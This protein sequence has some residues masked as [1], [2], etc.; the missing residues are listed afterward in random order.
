MP[1][2]AVAIPMPFAGI[3]TA[4]ANAL[5]TKN[6]PYENIPI[7]TEIV[8]A[9]TVPLNQKYDNTG[10]PNGISETFTGVP[11]EATPEP[12]F[13]PA[14][15]EENLQA[16]F[17]ANDWTDYLPI[18]L[19]TEARVQAMLA[20]TSHAADEVIKTVTW[21]GG[22]RQLTVEK[23]AICAVMAGASPKHFPAIL[24]ISTQ[25]P[26]GNSTTSMSN[27]IIFSGPIRDEIG[28]NYAG[29][30]MSPYS[31]A[32]AVC[33]RSLTIMSKTVGGL[34]AYG[35]SS[36][37]N[38]T[39]TTFSSLGSNIQY[40]NNCFGENEEALPPGWKT[41]AEIEGF[42]KL[43]SVVTV[44]TGWTYISS[45]GE[46]QIQTPVHEWIADYMHALSGQGGAT[47]FM[48]PLVANILY[49]GFNFDKE[50][51]AQYF[52]E[53]VVKTAKQLW[54]NGVIATFNTA[55]ALQGLEPW[56]TYYN[57]ARDPATADTPIH[58]LNNPQNINIVVVGG[59]TQTTWFATDFRVGRGINIDD[60]R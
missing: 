1:V 60:W 22:A 53:T 54:A 29:N 21:P 41:L 33:G 12:R 38:Q 24:A 49:E 45:V 17:K 47:V 42:T 8:A 2:R 4:M 51:L 28:I 7:T 52:S 15:T 44:G 56:L 36:P 13:L 55:S 39:A 40:N 14:D 46:A 35:T 26:Y 20:G 25:V 5:I 9:L 37:M 6:D 10:L 48:D 57:L 50:S 11:P 32:N 31:E 59:K 58:F 30:A 27:A 43:D 19:P 18:V 34:H 3:T 23:V 16:L